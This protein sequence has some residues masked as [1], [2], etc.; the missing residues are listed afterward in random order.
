MMG[1]DRPAHLIEALDLA[2]LSASAPHSNLRDMVQEADRAVRVVQKEMRQTAKIAHV[3][4][5]PRVL[6]LA[7]R[8]VE[9]L[10]RQESWLRDILR[11]RD[12]AELF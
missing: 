3:H 10:Q 6:S 2:G 4:G 12:G 7:E 9:V 8:F 5:D 11:K 1:R